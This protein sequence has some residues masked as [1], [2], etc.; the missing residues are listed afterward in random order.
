MI[1][2]VT[3]ENTHVFTMYGTIEGKEVK[4]M[5]ATYTRAE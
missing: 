5:E 4:M 3:D 2:E 1:T